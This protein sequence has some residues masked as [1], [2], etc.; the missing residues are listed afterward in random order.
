MMKW[1][2]V[3]LMAGLVSADGVP[4]ITYGPGGPTQSW[5]AGAECAQPNQPTKL[6]YDTMGRNALILGVLFLV[7]SYIIY[8][9]ITWSGLRSRRRYIFS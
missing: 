5:C 9:V 1:I 2:M 8:R 7:G 4:A 3:L 6:D